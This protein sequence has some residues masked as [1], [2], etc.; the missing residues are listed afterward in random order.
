MDLEKRMELILKEPTEEV[1]TEERLK[2][3]L[4]RGEKLRHYIG[5]EISGFVHLG[6]GLL[7][8]QKVA[9]FQ[10]AKVE[11]TIFLADFH[12][13][14][15]RKLGGD[16]DLI[17][18]VAGGYFKE[19]LK[20]SLKVVGGDVD[21]L[22]IVLGSELYEKL[23]IDYFESVLRI[24][25]KTT[26][27]RIKRSITIMGRK[28]GESLDFAQLLYIPMQ[29]ADVFALNVNLPHGGMDQR[30]A[31]VI[32]I[33]VGDKVF[34]YKP[35]AVHHHLLT[36]MHLSENE[37]KKILEA[38]R[39]GNRELFEESVLDI[40]MSKSKPESAVFIHDSEEEIRRKI[41]RAFCPAGETEL[42]PILEL[43][44]Y[45]IFRNV[46][47][48][49]IINQ[50]TGERK[51]FENYEALERAWVKGEIHPADLKNAV[52]EELIRILEPA[53]KHFLEGK[54]KKYI[55]EMNEIRITR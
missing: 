55:E 13:W 42:N 25:M 12:S 30:K 38:K 27:S 50:K 48:F 15:N 35:I 28:E 16:L 9:D 39:T 10:K 36:G 33:E 41:T 43:L 37:R 5:F 32:A 53:R 54:G 20:W 7:C 18:K 8:M 47:E 3:M 40:K 21:K 44:R 34:G 14:I 11:T 19:A 22:K 23:G 46:E 52:A 29:V 6:T 1:L 26:L 31:H 45:V 2:E 17:K 49:E 24:S 51:T 4:E